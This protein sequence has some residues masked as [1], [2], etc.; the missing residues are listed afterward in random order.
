MQN[1]CEN[2]IKETKNQPPEPAKKFSIE[3]IQKGNNEK[4]AYIVIKERVYDVTKLLDIHPGGK[5]AL[6]SQAGK[7]DPVTT[8]EFESIH[9]DSAKKWSQSELLIPSLIGRTNINCLYAQAI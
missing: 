3:E 4:Q 5:R 1:S 7:L 2:Q 6:L 9:N 8:D